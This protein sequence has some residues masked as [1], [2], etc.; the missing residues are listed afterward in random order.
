MRIVCV[1][2][3]TNKHYVRII[4][5][6][7]RVKMFSCINKKVFHACASLLL[8]VSLAVSAPGVGASEAP[9]KGTLVILGD[10]IGTGHSLPDYNS[11]GNPKSQY[12]WATLLSEKY[13]AKQ[14]NFAVDGDTTSDLL[15]VVNNA[16]KRRVIEKAKVICISIGGNNFLQL[17]G[18]LVLSGSVFDA[19]AVESAY[20]KMQEAAERDL[21]AIFAEL[22]EI[23]PDAKVLV[24]TLFEPYRYFEVQVTPDQTVAE[25]MGAFIDRYN[26]VLTA[27]AEAHGF[28]VVEV[29][30]KFETDGKENWVYASMNEGTL[31]DVIAAF[32]TANPHPTKDGHKGIFDAYCETAG[33]IFTAAF[34]VKDASGN[35][36]SGSDNK[37]IGLIIGIGVGVLLAGGACALM[38]VKKKRS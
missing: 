34:V 12:S 27:K 20:I 13:G 21:D 35:R 24:Q 38:I 28:T 26:A 25:W 6:E 10:S 19:E 11:S 1:I 32:A 2:M 8:A 33:E 36:G 18:G 22:K 16:S 31:A 15:A 30:R 4:T 29:A 17:M 9:E 23:N 7:S 3:I 14:I 5:Q 37:H